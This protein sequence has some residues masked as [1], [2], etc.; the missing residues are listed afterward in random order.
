MSVISVLNQ[1]GG[2]GKS[3]IAINLAVG[4]AKDSKKVLLIDTDHQRSSMIW[5]ANREE[6]EPPVSVI[7]IPEAGA[8]KRAVSDH[9]QNYDILIID[10]TPSEDRLTTI[11]ISVSDLVIVP[12]QPSALDF[13]STET[14]AERILQAQDLG[15]VKGRY[16]LTRYPP[17]ATHLGKEVEALVAE[18]EMPMFSTKIHNRI[19]YADSISANQS[20]WSWANGK[21]L[22][23]IESLYDEVREILNA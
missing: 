7:S 5:Y 12:L 8:L 3:T 13:W 4:F 23:E 6:E 1:K 17:T 16:L 22:E 10:G 9:Q 21:A 19:A 2:T 20:V 15:T 11:S 18:Q 14:L